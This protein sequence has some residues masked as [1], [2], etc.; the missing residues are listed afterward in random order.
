MPELPEVETVRRVLEP[1]IKGLSITQ[2]HVI[3]KRLVQMDDKE[4]ASSIQGK[5][6]LAVDRK[7][8]FLILHLSGD[9]AL[10]VH[11]RMEGK[12]FHLPSLEGNLTKYVTCYFDLS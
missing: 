1:E 2:A 10:L 8:K 7:G 11:F 3:Y 9:W 12:L 6:I 5:K 4:F